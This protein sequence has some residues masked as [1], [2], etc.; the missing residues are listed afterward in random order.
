MEK[1]VKLPE[2]ELAHKNQA[3][4]WWYFNGFLDGKKKYSFMTCLFKADKKK[5]N[6]NFIKVPIKTIYFSHSILFN[7]TDKKIEKEILPI[8]ILEKNKTEKMNLNYFYPLRKDFQNYEIAR[9]DDKIRLKTK[10]FDLFLEQNKK[11]LLENG[12]GYIDL[13]EKSTYYYSYSNMKAQG[14]IGKDFVKGIAWHDKQWSKE[15]FMKDSWLWFSFQL[16]DNTEIV[17]FDYKGKKLATI[18]YPDDKQETTIPEFTPLN[19]KWKSKTGLYY[20]LEWKIK[21]KNFEIYTKPIIKNCEM[22]FGF[23]NYWE[24]PLEVKING[25]NAKGFMEYL[26]DKKPSKI[27]EMIKNGQEKILKYLK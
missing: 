22:N 20:N 2:D 3:I 24:G 7:L 1:R 27:S 9:F 25:K 10:F 14:Y 13:G 15:G 16:P 17:C 11:P 5:V 12:K 26:A 19:K 6:L 21:I 23:I 18:S 4:E 8:V